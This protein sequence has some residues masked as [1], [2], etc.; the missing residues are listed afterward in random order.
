MG[1]INPVIFIFT[2]LDDGCLHNH[3]LLRHINI[4]K[5]RCMIYIL[6][7]QFFLARKRYIAPNEILGLFISRHSVFHSLFVQKRKKRGHVLKALSQTLHTTSS[8]DRVWEAHNVE[9]SSEY[10]DFIHHSKNLFDLLLKACRAPC[11]ICAA[12]NYFC[13]LASV[14]YISSYRTTHKKTTEWEVWKWGA[15]NTRAV[16]LAMEA[17]RQ[18]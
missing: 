4:V 1:L 18:C 8:T 15:S 10:I 6:V 13:V 12:F 9:D 5:C 16:D 7:I 17:K 14:I 2:A 3:C 11:V